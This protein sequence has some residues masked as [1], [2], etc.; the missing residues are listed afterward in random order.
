MF[1][2][3]KCGVSELLSM[4]HAFT[5]EAAGHHFKTRH[6]VSHVLTPCWVHLTFSRL[7]QEGVKHWNP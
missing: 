1:L 5:V 6:A 3:P 2:V 7:I 4:E